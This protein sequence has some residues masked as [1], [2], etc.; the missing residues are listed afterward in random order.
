MI[1]LVFNKYKKLGLEFLLNFAPQTDFRLFVD[2][3]IVCDT[4]YRMTIFE[5]LYLSHY[6]T[7]KQFALISCI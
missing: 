2:Y 4:L 5:L 3:K 7:F 1:Q 6:Y